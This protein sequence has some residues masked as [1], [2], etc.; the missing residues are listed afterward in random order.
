VKRFESDRLPHPQ[1]QAGTTG[2]VSILSGKGGVGKSVLAFN[3]AERAAAAGAR[4]LLVDNDLNFGNIHILANAQVNYGMAQFMREEL[5][6]PEAAFRTGIG[7]DILASTGYADIDEDEDSSVAAGRMIEKLRREGSAYDLIIIDHPSGISKRA[8]VAAHG[9]D[10]NLLVLVPE[11]TS[12]SDCYGLF[13]YLMMANSNIDCR[14]VVNRVQNESEAGYIISKLGA[15]CDRFIGATPRHA[16]TLCESD[17]YR[18]SVGAQST[19]ADLDPNSI[20]VKE[21][22][23]ITEGLLADFGMSKNGAKTTETTKTEMINKTAALADIR[24]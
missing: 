11:L 16:G 10:I 22:T 6:L 8:T 21:V 1:R 3:L 17:S 7:F 18:Q 9:S 4:V 23:L 5:S 15:L 24:E 12:I 14:L 19:L 13:K 20:A 2:I